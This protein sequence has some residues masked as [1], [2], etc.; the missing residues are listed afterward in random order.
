MKTNKIIE[1]RKNMDTNSFSILNNSKEAR[2]Y[3][4]NHTV[5]DFLEATK[6][7]IFDCENI[8]FKTCDT[9]RVI[10][11]VKIDYKNKEIEV[12][13]CIANAHIID[14]EEYSF[15]LNPCEFGRNLGFILD[16]KDDLNFCDNLF[17]R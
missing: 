6:N 1:K 14:I 10:D 12:P 5:Q 2:E 15:P 7:R 17:K 11:K 13:A 3:F 4:S 8:F 9:C 16:I